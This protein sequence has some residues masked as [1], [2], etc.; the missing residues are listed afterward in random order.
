MLFQWFHM[1][2][3]FQ[4][5]MRK[6]LL[7]LIA[8]LLIFCGS[9]NTYAA[10]PVRKAVIGHAALNARV[11]PLWVA[12]DHGFFVKYGVNAN[13]IFIRQAPVLVA[14]LTAGDVHAAYTGGTT[15]LTAVTSGAD[16]KTIATLTNRLG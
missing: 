14:A 9:V 4:C 10:T 8:V 1:F 7:P 6:M 5:S 11:A 2:Q 3:R 12:E 16:L 13:A 15:V